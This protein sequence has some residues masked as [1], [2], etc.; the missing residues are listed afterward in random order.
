MGVE[1]GQCWVVEGRPWSNCSRISET[2]LGTL[3]YC[4]DAHCLLSL[5]ED[6]RNGKGTM[7]RE[8]GIDVMWKKRDNKNSF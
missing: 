2:T 7:E 6:E 1:K 3:V 4:R 8:K 5:L